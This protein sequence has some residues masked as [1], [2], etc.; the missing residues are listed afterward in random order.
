MRF[1]AAIINSQRVASRSL[2]RR[3]LSMSAALRIIARAERT[4]ET[5]AWRCVAEGH[6]PPIGDVLELSPDAEV[7][8]IRWT[9]R[10]RR[11]LEVYGLG[12]ELV[13]RLNAATTPPNPRTQTSRFGAVMARLSLYEKLSR[14]Y[15]VEAAL[16]EAAGFRLLPCWSRRS[17]HWYV[18]S[19]RKRL[20]CARHRHAEYQRKYRQP[21][22]AASN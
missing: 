4:G 15:P 6:L 8:E 3:S 10:R 11:L 9:A 13:Q 17:P 19:N 21:R 22:S 20:Y 7:S 16:F 18:G 12:G 1:G 5:A 2:A 14:S